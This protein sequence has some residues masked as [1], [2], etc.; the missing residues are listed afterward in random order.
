M[1]LMLRMNTKILEFYKDSSAVTW[2]VSRLINDVPSP[3]EYVPCNLCGFD[4]PVPYMR[5]GQFHVVRCAN[6]SLVYVNP[7]LDDQKYRDLYSSDAYFMAGFDAEGKQHNCLDEAETKKRDLIYELDA[8]ESLPGGRILDI[9]CGLGF[10][11]EQLSSKWIGYGCDYS[12]F[13]VDYCRRKGLGTIY[14]GDL[15]D[16]KLDDVCFDVVSARYVLEHLKDPGRFLGEISRILKPGGRLVVSIPN[17]GSLCAK[18]FG[19]FFR[20]NS[21]DEHIYWFTRATLI[22]YLSK[23]GFQ[24]E[25]VVYPYFRTSYFNTKELWHFLERLTLLKVV[26]PLGMILHARINR[27]V[28]SPPFYGN[29][30]MVVARKHVPA[31]A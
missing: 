30:I 2:F 26:M 4:R 3:R 17:W 1:G 15:Y 27:C 19:E 29:I 21:P 5:L 25:T 12:Q 31:A 18:L 28:I 11:L 7:R 13:A 23:N 20:L 8:I 16:L 9:G 6:C 10:L 22:N 24:V 14:H